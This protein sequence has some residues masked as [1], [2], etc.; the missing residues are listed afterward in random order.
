MYHI[1]FSGRKTMEWLRRNAYMVLALLWVG[2]VI[3]ALS[4]WERTGL[5]VVLMGLYII[6]VGSMVITEAAQSVSSVKRTLDFL[7]Y[8]EDRNEGDTH[9]LF[10][11]IASQQED[12]MAIGTETKAALT[13]LREAISTEADQA[14][15][16]IIAATN[17]DAATADAIRE[18][19][20]G[21]K[22]IIPDDVEETDIPTTGTPADEPAPETPVDAPV[23][24]APVEDTPV[25]DEPAADE[26][27]EVDPEA[28]PADDA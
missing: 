14:V 19:I 5:L 6:V 1:E 24:D 8:R 21:V 13:E 12:I 22:G 23:E 2:L 27:V 16:K 4:T 26:P 18:A 20:S 7:E 9:K 25:A 3:I 15:E 11:A 28:L 10:A 17:A